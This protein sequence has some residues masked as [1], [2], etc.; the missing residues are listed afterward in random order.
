[1]I[2]KPVVR[3]CAAGWLRHAHRIAGVEKQG[4]SLWHIFRCKWATDRKHYPVADV[5]AADGWR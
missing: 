2:Q 5:A 4:G 1:V 3:Y